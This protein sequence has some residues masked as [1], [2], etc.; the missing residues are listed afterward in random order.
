[1]F[2]LGASS[3]PLPTLM[4]ASSVCEFRLPDSNLHHPAKPPHVVKSDLTEIVL[5]ANAR[6]CHVHQ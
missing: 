4:T 1:M 2:G 6:S 3:P 5:W